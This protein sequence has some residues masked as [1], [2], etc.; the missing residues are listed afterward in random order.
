MAWD[1]KP[2]NMVRN[3]GIMAHIDAGKTTTTERVLFYTGKKHKIWETHDWEAD[4]DWMEQ[5]KER[6]ITITSATTAC[7]WRDHH[8]NI[9]DT[10]G[11]VDFTIE[12][13][14]SLRVLDGAVALL[15]WS[16]WVEPQTETVWRQADKYNVPR[17]IYVN[18]M[19]KLGADFYMSVDSIK[20]RITDKGVVVQLPVGQADEFKAVI[21]LLKM[22]MYTFEWNMW[23]EVKEHEIPAD[24]LAKSQEYREAMIDKVSM[25]DDEL[26]EKFLGGEEIS[27]DLIKRA[28]R[29][30][31]IS[32]QL[33]PIMCGSSLG[34]K[35]T[36]L[37]L[38]AVVD[39][40]PSPLDRGAMKGHDV[41]DEEKII[42]RNPDDKEPVSAIAFKILTDPFV[43]TL[44]YVRVYSGVIHSG[45]SLLNPI[46]WQR[47]RV[48]RLLLMHANKRE[49]ISEIHA[50]HICA[51]LGLK[52]TRT[53]NTLC[54]EKNPV[55]L[56]KMTFPEPVIDIAIE[57]KSKADQEKMGLALSK[58]SYE[59]PSF[60]YY[61]D[62]E[63]NQTIIAGMGE[64][65]LE[66]IVDR[67]KREHKVEV[68]TG[69][70]QVSYRETITQS[71]QGE[72]VFKKQ[73]WGRGQFGHVLLRL[74]RLEEKDYEFK[75]EVTGGR[76]PKEFIP[77]IDKGAKET[78]AQGIL[79]GF[80]I[81]NV[82]VCPY[83]G[84]Y[85]DVDSSEIA[86]KIATYKWF[87][88][89]FMKAGPV[90]L[91][92]IMNVE[93]VTPEEYVG[94][95]MWDLSSRRGMIQWQDKRWN[96]A[97][98]RA[99]VPLSEMF[100]YTTDLRSN[101]QGRAQSSMEFANYEKVPEAVA[102]KIIEERAGAWKIKKMDEE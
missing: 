19:D 38:D 99:K 80:P 62:K 41:N 90:I 71:A 43:G 98:V 6:G 36:Q 44:T 94:T 15:D 92:P 87:K 32:T 74:E 83:D 60:R 61:T 10:P 9:I 100:W 77:A 93:V 73:S 102:K 4:M 24:M 29:N 67:L 37:M 31:V 86:F 22:K 46:T 96:G 52:D 11:H 20:S 64:L 65:H 35:G 68:I 34:N 16:Q 56:E 78:I 101:T 5:E 84:S 48:W 55:I 95:V 2:L 18:K 8:I 57:P 88:D 59:D 72:W 70:P 7:F 82:R 49:E 42:E 89:A 13:E 33:Y 25:F 45:D 3:I 54:D 79:A 85:H 75:D 81:I 47:E 53:G 69:K 63:S 91:E 97:V 51:F 58:L 27:I 76:I 21:D 17:V 26:A 40:F 23:I 1:R 39:Y 14:R 66:I 30:W 28:I 50:G 12:V